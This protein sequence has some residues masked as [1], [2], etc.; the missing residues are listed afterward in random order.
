M[1]GRFTIAKKLTLE[2]DDG[3]YPLG[4]DPTTGQT[5]A[6]SSLGPPYEK[7]HPEV[8]VDPNTPTWPTSKFK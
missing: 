5:V 8:K 7:D 1:S 6:Q 2:E 4:T 3:R